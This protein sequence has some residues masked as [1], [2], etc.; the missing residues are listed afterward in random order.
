MDGNF[1]I[2]DFLLRKFRNS[3][4]LQFI[5]MENHKVVVGGFVN[6]TFDSVNPQFNR[7]VKSFHGVIREFFRKS[8][9]SDI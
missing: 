8:A 7:G 1:Y 6:I 4:A 5:I 3:P 2:T 9:V